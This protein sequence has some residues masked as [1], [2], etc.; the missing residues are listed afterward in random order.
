MLGTE[1]QLFVV[2]LCVISIDFQCFVYFRA[3][4]ARWKV[5][6]DGGVGI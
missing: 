3:L 5:G 2:V 6:R 1:N 4:M